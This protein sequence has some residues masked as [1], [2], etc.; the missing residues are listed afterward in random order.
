MYQEISYE[1]KFVSDIIEK[2]KN[3][4]YNV[5][6]YDNIIILIGN[7]DNKLK[8]VIS[9]E[10]I[11]SREDQYQNL[12]YSVKKIILCFNLISLYEKKLFF[13]T[14][15]GSEFFK[16]YL[17]ASKKELSNLR[18]YIRLTCQKC[19]NIFINE[20][21]LVNLMFMRLINKDNNINRVLSKY[22]VIEIF[23]DEF[24]NLI[25]SFN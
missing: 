4:S 10:F 6:N 2:I 3:F 21:P 19:K 24:Q 16:C 8:K 25:K 13:E 11:E 15:Y 18:C 17:K 14:T 20:Q 22:K 9:D 7:I 23:L 1:K 12:K 5:N